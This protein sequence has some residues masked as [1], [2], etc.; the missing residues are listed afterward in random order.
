M[1]RYITKKQLDSILLGDNIKWY[2]FEEKKKFIQVEIME[3]TSNCKLYR[4][5]RKFK[6][7]YFLYK[8]NLILK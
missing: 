1:K 8:N 5:F 2:S 6:H 4:I 7:S 3:E